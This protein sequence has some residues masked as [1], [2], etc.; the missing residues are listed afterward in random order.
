ME[1]ASSTLTRRPPGLPEGCVLIIRATQSPVIDFDTSN[2]YAGVAVPIP[3]LLLSLSTTSVVVSTIKS[4]PAPPPNPTVTPPADAL[5]P[6]AFAPVPAELIVNVCVDP[7]ATLKVRSLFEP[8]TVI[9][10][11]SVPSMEIAVPSIVTT[12]LAF[13][14]KI[15]V[16][17]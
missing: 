2:V 12:P 8:V 4:S 14:S 9:L 11:S 1:S 13:K 17:I 7:P 3:T 5:I 15:A 16:S 6:I 10:E